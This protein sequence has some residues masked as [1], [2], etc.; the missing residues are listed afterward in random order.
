[1]P[2]LR[3]HPFFTANVR[4]LLIG[5]AQGYRFNR[6]S[7]LTSAENSLASRRALALELHTL[8]K[9]GVIQRKRDG[10]WRLLRRNS[11]SS[12]ASV[13]EQ[14][15]GFLPAAARVYRENVADIDTG[16]EIDA[17]P[18]VAQLL[19]YYHSALRSDVRGQAQLF[20]DR[21]G[22][23]WHNFTAQGEWWPTDRRIG[24]LELSLESLDPNFRA[25]LERRAGDD[26]MAVGWGLANGR[27]RGVE[28]IWPVGILAARWWRE[29]DILHVALERADTIANPAWLRAE[30]GA[31]GWNAKDLGTRLGGGQDDGVGPGLDL[32]QFARVLREAAAPQIRGRLWPQVIE[33][34]PG[35]EDTGIWG[36]AAL[37]LPEEQSMT[38]RAVRDLDRIR[39]WDEAS[40]QSTALGALL[41]PEKAVSAPA[42]G[43]VLE[44]GQLNAEQIE[45]TR[46]GLTRR[47]TVVTGPPGTGKSQT[48]AALVSSA[49]LS[50]KRVL[51]AARNHQ[52]LDAI[53]ERIG[54]NRVI[55]TRDRSGERNVSIWDAARELVGCEDPASSSVSLDERI[56]RLAELD[57]RRKEALERL[58]ERRSL[59]FRLA[60]LLE[61][62]PSSD[63]GPRKSLFS[64]LMAKFFGRRA[65]PPASPEIEKLRRAARVLSD[66]E[67]PVAL[68]AEI[69]QAVIEI[70]SIA[71]DIRIALGDDRRAELGRRLKDLDLEGATEM[72]EALVE[73]VLSARPVWLTTTLSAPARLPLKPGLFDLLIVDEASQSDI[74][75]AVPLFARAGRAVV[76]GDDRQLSFIPAI[77][78]AHEINL[79][80]TAG[81]R[82]AQGMGI[83]AQGTSSLF[84]LAKVQCASSTEG[85]AIMLREQYRSAPDITEFIGQQFYGGK[86]RPAVNPERLVV[87][88]GAR[89]GLMWTDVPGQAEVSVE[90]GYVNRKEVTSIAAHLR[91]LLLEQGYKGT[92]GV[93]TPFNAQAGALKRQIHADIPEGLR[94]RAALKIDTIDSFQGEERALI[95]FSP[96]ATGNDAPGA[97][98]FLA[99]DWRRLNVAISRAQ[100]VAHVF[101]DPDFAASGRVPALSRLHAVIKEPRRHAD[102]EEAGSMWERRLG[103]ALRDGG[104]TPLPQYRILGR[105]L[106]FAIITDRVRL[107]I[108]VDGRRWHLDIDG[109][110]KADDIFRDAQLRAAGWRVL[111]F[112]VSELDKSMEECV[113]RI[114]RE[115]G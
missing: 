6:I 111:R 106:D 17:R 81:I 13:P 50:G 60:D 47:L 28:V 62:A 59:E 70:L 95:L 21:A 45:A 14:G 87:P 44:T 71:F 51:V 29:T 109:N 92:I 84:D 36:A 103:A 48:V 35:A 41:A 93:V 96:V 53:E 9:S 113:D 37:I 107:N 82:S 4:R 88:V 40:I 91:Q 52:A 18:S 58:E 89:P 75:S 49:I 26:T 61:A 38:R 115:L 85:R 22:K 74:A 110:R 66:I 67:N 94:A 30:A 1:M 20:P 54:G 79:M 34:G 73:T 102:D 2:A 112:W 15:S 98:A 56:A 69:R 78:R 16:S 65:H 76:V 63:G 57:E 90:G 83:F 8:Q 100:A 39:A 33:Q 46:S 68:G 5:S 86:L 23:S 114:K 24:R 31:L 99:R 11:R 19:A 108:E 32:E 10:A 64:L 27:D 97:G 72:P 43:P 104:L 42:I 80:R 101:G 12:P 55:R 77:G 105:R 25:A 3:E 7:E